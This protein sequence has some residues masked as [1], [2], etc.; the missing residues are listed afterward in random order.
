[1]TDELLNI[2]SRQPLLAK[3]PQHL[4]RKLLNGA[5]PVTVPRGQTVV[6]QGDRADGLSL[7]FE[8]MIRVYRLFPEG[9]EILIRLMQGGDV[10]LTDVGARD[11]AP[12]D[13]TFEAIRDTQLVTLSKAHICAC[14]AE[15]PE[16]ALAL[17]SVFNKQAQCLADEI[18]LVKWQYLP[19][20]VASF[21]VG[22]CP[23]SEG[24]TCFSL[25]YEKTL[26]AARLGVSRESLSRTFGELKQVGVDVQH[27]HI[28][29]EDPGRLRQFAETHAHDLRTRCEKGA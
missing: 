15:H 10:I 21:L 24:P 8:G 27:S 3:L 28:T 22:L 5:L 18:T 17:L 14:M 11:D 19:Q 16:I 26:I 1:M 29:I 7:I 25:P 9:K 4:I 20:R 13:E 23:E 6:M 2:I 12:Y